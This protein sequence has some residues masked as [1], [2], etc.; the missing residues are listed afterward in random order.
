MI[1]GRTT[2]Q[3]AA[4]KAIFTAEEIAQQPAVWHKTMERLASV[5]SELDRFIS[6]VT[7]QPDYDVILTGAGTSEYV[8]NTLVSALHIPYNGH[9]FSFGTTDIV[10]TPRAYLSP[11]KPTLLVSFARSGNSPESVGAV[12][13]A[14]TICENVWHLFITCNAEGALAK[15]AATRKNCFSIVLTPE[16]NDR[17]F[18]MTSSFTGMY[19]AAL[20]AFL[21]QQEDALCAVC[22]ASKRF[23]ESGYEKLKEISF[24]FERIVYLG[25][26]VLKG[27][28]QE[29]ALKMLELTG[30][31]VAAIFD[32]PMG[33]RHGPKSIVNDRT[34]TVVYLSDETSTRRYEIDLLKE[35]WRDKRGS[36]LL[37]VGNRKDETAETLCDV[38]LNFDSGMELKN[39]LLALP[40]IGAAQCLALFRSLSLNI[41]PDDPCPSGEVNRVVKGVTIYPVEGI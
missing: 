41:T 38:Y 28:A 34:L 18:A 40:Y 39:A 2:Q 10:A 23:L 4:Q 15:A 3:W 14:D 36:T 29:S 30:G 25:T 35:L 32:T 5:R 37:A 19:L 11:K 9:V 22:N 21:P 24:P 33:F 16:T 31:K 27:V 26:D 17:S 13:A 6:N 12:A 7:A 8:G 20:I 1:F